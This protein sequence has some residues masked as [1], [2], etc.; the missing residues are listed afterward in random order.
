LVSKTGLGKLGINTEKLFENA[1]ADENVQ[2]LMAEVIKAD[3]SLK[4]ASNEAIIIALAMPKVDLNGLG[5]EIA[6]LARM[7]IVKAE[8]QSE[9]GK[10]A[11]KARTLL[12]AIGR[13]SQIDLSDLDS[14]PSKKLFIGGLAQASAN[15]SNNISV[16]DFNPMI[17]N[18]AADL[19]QLP[20]GSSP[21][22]I[23]TRRINETADKAG[24]AQ[25][26]RAAKIEEWLKACFGKA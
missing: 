13:A 10:S 6:E 25:E 23:I 8:P 7:A 3:N 16:G 5:K 26:D 20:A 11:A 12:G 21:D 24:V 4:K 2:A 19:I 14:N 1:A 15:A 18:M 22:E 17:L 9:A